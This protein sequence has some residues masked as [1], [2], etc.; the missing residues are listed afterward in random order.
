MYNDVKL[1]VDEIIDLFDSSSSIKKMLALKKEL[2]SDKTITNKLSEYEKLLINPYDK[3][4][5][6]IKKEL[7]NDKRFKDYKEYEDKLFILTLNINSILKS[8]LKEKSCF[9]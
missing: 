2:L 3:R 8:V 9:K 6:E 5:V 7:L 1:K 4:C